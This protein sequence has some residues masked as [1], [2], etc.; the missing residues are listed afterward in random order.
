M[1]PA[2]GEVVLAQEVLADAQPEIA[3]AHTAWV[4]AATVPILPTLDDKATEVLVAPSQVICK[5]ACR[6]VMVLSPRP[7]ERAGGG[8]LE[9][10]QS[11]GHPAW[12]PSTA[13]RPAAV[14][15]ARASRRTTA[16]PHQSRRRPRTLR[17]GTTTSEWRRAFPARPQSAS[18]GGAINFGGLTWPSLS[19]AI[20]LV[21]PRAQPLSHSPNLACTSGRPP[22]YPTTTYTASHLAA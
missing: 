6:S 7:A 16:V 10:S 3:E 14:A 2:V 1:L 18:A 4:A 13:W 21:R 22:A 19:D 9:L 20:R 11:R 8:R 17:V 15:D 12:H 5:V